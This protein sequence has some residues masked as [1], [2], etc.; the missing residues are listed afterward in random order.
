MRAVMYGA[1]N[2]GR[3]FI[4][5]RFYLS[6]YETVFIDVNL[7]AVESLKKEKKYPIFVTR[8]DHYEAEWVEN[9]TAVNGRDED[10][11]V[12]EIANCEIMATALGVN[13][14]PFVAKNIARAIEKRFANG[15]KPLNILICENLIGSGEYLKGLV[16]PLVA[17]EAKEYLES[18]IGFVSVSVCITVPPT[19]EKFLAE[20]PVAVC[21]DVYNELPADAEAFRP[22]GAPVPNVNGLVPFSPFRFYI[23]R[24][25]LIHNMGHATMAYLGWLKHYN[26]IYEVAEDAEVKYILYRAL[27]ESARA[28][29]K[30]HGVPLDNLMRFIEN[31]VTRLD[32]PLLDDTLLR[33][34]KDTKRK[35]NAG[36]R[37]AGAYLMCREQGILPAHIAVSIAAGYLFAPAEDPIAIEVSSYAKENGI[38]AALEKYS[39]I[40]EKA[41]VELIGRFY[42]MLASGAKFGAIVKE[43]NKICE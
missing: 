41:D 5:K 31:L 22:V 33:V 29:S 7:S 18:S 28:L 13:V 12:D 10:A 43:L 2:I 9:V 30:R 20:S 1:G 21:S 38:A 6:G 23:E 4:A 19:A 42:D 25:L 24:K 27:C 37:L 16:E 14:L 26:Y 11:V 3:G 8:G 39:S 32:N 35:L 17:P 40:T 34:G 15:A 36:D